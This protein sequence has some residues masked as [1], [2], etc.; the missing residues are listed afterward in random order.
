M[1]VENPLN[2]SE[3]DYIVV[4]CLHIAGFV[5]TIGM[6]AVVD[7]RLLGLILPK[8]SP[9]QLAWFTSWDV[10]IRKSRAVATESNSARLKPL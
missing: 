9:Q 4:E 8:Q 2:L 7:F 1:A 10:R 5:L 6:T 3:N